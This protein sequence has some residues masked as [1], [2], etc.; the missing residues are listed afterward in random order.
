MG[1]IRRLGRSIKKRTKKLFSSKLGRIIGTIA[2]GYMLGPQGFDV[3]GRLGNI[4][5][6]KTGEVAGEQAVQQVVKE[7]AKEEVTKKAVEEGTKEVVSNS[8]TDAIGKTV[9]IVEKDPSFLEKF[10]TNLGEGVTNIKEG[11]TEFAADP[12]GK[13]GEYLGGEFVPDV[14]RGVTTGLISAEIMGEP[15]EQFVGGGL[16]PQPQQEAAQNS[17]V[18]AV[19][20]QIPQMQGMNFQQLNQSLLYGTLTPQF[21]IGQSQYT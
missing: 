12:I 20:N 6:T 10:T 11:V 21:L 3:F 2:I 17:Y 15:E 4:V 13:T 16:L 9:D 5:G 7:K 18:Q 14:A 1:A 8:L 19:Q